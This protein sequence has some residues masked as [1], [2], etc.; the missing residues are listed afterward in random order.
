VRP[1]SSSGYGG[2]TLLVNQGDVAAGIS[3]M[4]I[5]AVAMI[6]LIIVGTA[7]S[8]VYSG[9]VYY[10]ALTGDAPA[11]FDRALIRGAFGPKE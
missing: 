5:G 6:G 2:G 7:L 9:A 8:A 4:V 3:L 11:G 1:S 10:F